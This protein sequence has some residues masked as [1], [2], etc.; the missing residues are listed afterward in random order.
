MNIG[1]FVQAWLFLYFY[2]IFK[3]HNVTSFH[4]FS[5]NLEN[6][7]QHCFM[8]HINVTS[9]TLFRHPPELEDVD[10]LRLSIRKSET[11]RS[12]N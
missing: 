9:H 5:Q 10:D 3:I 12:L 6:L 8:L 4:I 11:D 7:C 2:Q 1:Q